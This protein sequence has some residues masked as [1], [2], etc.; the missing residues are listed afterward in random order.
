M[1]TKEFPLKPLMRIAKKAGV[2]RI[3]TDAL[4]TLRNLTLEEAEECAREIVSLARHA[5]RKT[6]LKRDVEFVVK[7]RE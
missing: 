2:K 6:I 1:R 5:G 4:K 3:S 7:R